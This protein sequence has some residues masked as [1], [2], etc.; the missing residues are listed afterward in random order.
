[1]TYLTYSTIRLYFFAT[2]KMCILAT[3]ISY[4]YIILPLFVF[5]LGYIILCLV[6]SQFSNV[7]VQ[8]LIY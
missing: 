7:K 4:Y 8:R 1:M 2:L 5:L 6:I 3:M